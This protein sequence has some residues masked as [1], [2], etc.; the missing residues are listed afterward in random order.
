MLSFVKRHRI[1]VA[2]VIFCLL[3][4]HLASNRKKGTGG[5]AIVRYSLSLAARPIQIT[6]ASVRSRVKGMWEGYI[7]L[8]GIKEENEALNKK[9]YALLEENNRLKE[10]IGLNERLRDLLKF[11]EESPY[12]V[13]AAKILSLNG[14][15]TGEN[16]TRTLTLDRGTISG[17]MVDMPVVSTQG[18]IGRVIETLKHTSTVLLLTDPRSDIDVI[19]Q[20]TRIHGIVEGGSDKLILKYIRQFDDVETG[21]MVVTSGLSGIFPK[22]LQVGMVTR[23]E[24]GE[25]NIFRYIEVNPST[26]LRRLEEVLVI[27]QGSPLSGIENAGNSGT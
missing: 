20:R 23:V 12:P 8:V 18:V 26:D 4:L 25:D 24:K 21:D 15:G 17:I 7:Y 27:T 11:K 22:G 2:S 16:W 3:S 6:L 13:V 10:E 5:E 9:M 19:I 14:F 1:I